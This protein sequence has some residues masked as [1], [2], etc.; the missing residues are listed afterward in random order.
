MPR[1]SWEIYKSQSGV[2]RLAWP[3]VGDEG[4]GSAGQAKKR[5]GV[6]GLEILQGSARGGSQ[7]GWSFALRGGG[8]RNGRLSWRRGLNAGI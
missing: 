3:P 2:K 8:E 6:A 1:H 4:H 5:S 7:V